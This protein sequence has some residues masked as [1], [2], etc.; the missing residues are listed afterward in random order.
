LERYPDVGLRWA[1]KGKRGSVAQPKNCLS[2]YPTLGRS[3][4]MG[5]VAQNKQGPRRKG[6]R[7]PNQGRGVGGKHNTPRSFRIKGQYQSFEAWEK[8]MHKTMLCK[9][10]VPSN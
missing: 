1:G 9:E 2:V 3:E 4:T 6:H 8:Q 10:D 7:L 5:G